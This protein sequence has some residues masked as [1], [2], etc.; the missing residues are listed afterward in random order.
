MENSP[1]EWNNLLWRTL[2]LKTSASSQQVSQKQGGRRCSDL[3][4]CEQ[5]LDYFPALSVL[6]IIS[7]KQWSLK[8]QSGKF[9]ST[10]KY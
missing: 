8:V 3:A 5:F 2:T 7:H 4:S 1:R 9:P 10:L 6:D